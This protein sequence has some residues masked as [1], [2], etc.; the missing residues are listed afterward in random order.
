MATQAPQNIS[1]LKNW[2]IEFV[3]N[4]FPILKR[5][6]HGKPLVYLDN[7]ATT[8]KPQAVID[9]ITHF[10]TQGNANI[11]RGVHLLSEEATAA[12]EQARKAIANFINAPDPKEIIFVRG[13]TE[14][15]NLVAQSFGRMQC[16]AGDTVLIT[17]LEHHANIVPWQLL[18]EQIGIE[19]HVVPMD[20][21]GILD[22]KIL[23][24]K[25]ALRPKLFGIVHLSNVLGI[26]NPVAKM[27]TLARQAD[28]PVLIDAA[29]S[30]PHFMVDVQELD[31]DFLAFSGHKLFGP[32]GIGVLYGKEKWLNAMPPYQGGGDMIRSVSFEKTTFNAIPERFEAGTP[33]IAGAIGLAAAVNY[34]KQL[35]TKMLHA[36][37]KELYAYA[38]QAL[39]TIKGLE[40][41]GKTVEKMG[42]L[43]FTL[44]NIH[45]HDIATLLD[46]DGIAVR[47]GHQCAQPIMQRLG[48]SGLTRASFSFYNKREEIDQLV[49]SLEKIVKLF[50]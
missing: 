29:Q 7:A 25:L 19:L 8:Q 6:V 14:A 36:Y 1:D 10:Y 43:S 11:H 23:E 47:A 28:V 5:K 38:E 33:N 31:C 48:V 18:A 3:R 30:A 13:A 22:E 26:L 50:H 15:I 4:D 2:D 21:N 35:D 9:T 40:V 41:K 46:Q 27:I 24:Q 44:N 34:L 42:A 39:A 16:R 45:P 49:R 12:Y 37:E 32:T 20:E 17:H